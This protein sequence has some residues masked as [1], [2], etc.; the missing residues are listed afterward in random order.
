M[1]THTYVFHQ[2][3]GAP[4][5]TGTYSL[6]AKVDG[7]PADISVDVTLDAAEETVVDQYDNFFHSI[8]FAKA[9]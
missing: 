1:A 2:V 4:F 7:V 5:N 6:E 8:G 9:P 3:P